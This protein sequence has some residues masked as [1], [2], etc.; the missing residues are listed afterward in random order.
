M[1]AS[2][3]IPDLLAAPYPDRSS[4]RDLWVLAHRPERN[5]LN[6]FRPYAYLVEEEPDS[7]GAILSVAT[8]FLTNRDC[9]WRFCSRPRRP[10][11]ECYRLS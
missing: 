9:P 5:R 2:P 7:T 8:V 3:A 4:D 10:S 6:P 1:S 11:T